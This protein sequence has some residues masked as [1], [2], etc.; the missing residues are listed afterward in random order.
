MRSVIVRMTVRVIVRVIVRRRWRKR[1]CILVTTVGGA[2]LRVA[3]MLVL[4]G[5]TRNMR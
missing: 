2:C 5:H 3:T 4:G 1:W